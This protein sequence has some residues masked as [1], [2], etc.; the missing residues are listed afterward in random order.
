M[1]NNS[2]LQSS[3]HIYATPD[4]KIS[5][6]VLSHLITNVDD[7]F[8]SSNVMDVHLDTLS[9]PNMRPNASPCPSP[10]L[11]PV[12][13]PLTP[14]TPLVLTDSQCEKEFLNDISHNSYE[15]FYHIQQIQ[16][17]NNHYSYHEQYEYQPPA[18]FVQNSPSPLSSGA[19]TPTLSKPYDITMSYSHNPPNPNIS[20]LI[21]LNTC[22]TCNYD[23]LPLFNT[24][25]QLNTDE[26]FDDL[27]I[28][29]EN[30]ENNDEYFKN[31][32]YNH[33]VEYQKTRFSSGEINP[34]GNDLQ[35]GFS[36][37][38]DKITT[39]NNILSQ[40][41]DTQF[42]EMITKLNNLDI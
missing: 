14:I 6:S 2:P 26:M 19:S 15:Y 31:F 20:Q 11:R 24:S 7:V 10:I 30:Y 33:N 3:A 37:V 39:S 42:H 1:N 32:Y 35:V 34:I 36:S 29:N 27:I 22:N 16:R 23:S 8:H 9:P 12:S 28:N 18:S 5:P 40:Q 13:S 41:K 21:T 25:S 17:L 4:R 38:S